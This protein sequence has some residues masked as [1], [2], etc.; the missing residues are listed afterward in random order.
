MSKQQSLIPNLNE[1]IKEY[2][3]SEEETTLELQTIVTQEEQ[4]EVRTKTEP[5]IEEGR[6]R[7]KNAE[8]GETKQEKE[9]EANEFVSDRAFVFMEKMMLKKD[10]ISPFV[11]VI[12]QKGWSLLCKHHLA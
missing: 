2:A 6:K 5:P 12:E 4:P 7:K 10:F 8:E 9:D 1:I 3:G 11:E